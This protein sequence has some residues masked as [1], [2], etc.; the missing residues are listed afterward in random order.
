MFA[1]RYRNRSVLLLVA[2]VGALAAC[3]TEPDQSAP[4]A[5]APPNF[6][7][8]A[9][10]KAT[11]EFVLQMATTDL[12]SAT[13]AVASVGGRIE[14]VAGSLALYQVTGIDGAKAAQLRAKSGVVDVGADLRQRYVPPFS[15]ARRANATP[16]SPVGAQGTDQSAAFFYPDQWNIRRVNANQAW[17]ATP[18]GAGALVCVLDTG[19]DPG[20]LD[21][22]GKV[23]LAK[24]ASMVASE[25]FIE[26]L[27]FHGTYV[28]SLVSS[29]GLGMASVAPDARLCAVKVLDETGTGSFFDVML[30]IIHAADQGADVINMSLSGYVDVGNRDGRFFFEI[31][32]QVVAYARSQGSLVVASSGNDGVDMDQFPTFRVV[33]AQVPG[34]LGVSASAPFNRTKFDQLAPYSNV[35]RTLIDLM[36]PGGDFV[37]GGILTDL[38]VGACSRYVCGADGFYVFASGTSGAAP[39][40]AGAAAVVESAIAGD[41]SSE[42]LHG[43]LARGATVVNNLARKQQGA[44]RVDV[45]AAA[46]G[47]C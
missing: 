13:A 1:T 15:A 9:G 3:S 31:F 21:L 34:V 39:H 32:S 18:G 24:S 30:G 12:A 6:A 10:A 11:N 38:V 17:A 2:A 46:T 47:G 4:D 5:Q 40:V 37:S 16:F 33:P 41:Q 26:D 7:P 22:L 27:N 28:S 25:P 20:Q 29:N 14:R 42:T 44:G 23:D 36:A 19:V 43:C 45:L 35:G 8:L